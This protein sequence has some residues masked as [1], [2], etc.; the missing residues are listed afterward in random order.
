MF[1][2]RKSISF[3]K[4]ISTFTLIFLLLSCFAR[5]YVK[6]IT[7]DKT[8]WL[9][10][11]SPYIDNSVRAA[12]AR[13]L[14][15]RKVL[16]GKSRSEVIEMLGELEEKDHQESKE[17]SYTIG[18]AYFGIEPTWTEFLIISIDDNN[19]VKDVEIYLRHYR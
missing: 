11:T 1:I 5:P 8:K 14:V 12:M 3:F 9:E 13:D 6:P 10:Q 2:K 17:I 15:N 16:I 18:E 19:K 4:I 7:F